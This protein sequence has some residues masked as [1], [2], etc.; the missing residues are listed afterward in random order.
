MLLT[1]AAAPVGSIHQEDHETGECARPEGQRVGRCPEA[2]SITSR[3]SNWAVLLRHRIH[4][5]G[6]VTGAAGRQ[7]HFIAKE[8]PA[9]ARSAP[10]GM[11][12]PSCG[13]QKV[14]QVPARLARQAERRFLQ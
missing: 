6:Q 7:P 9:L 12:C 10:W 2:A 11:P 3:T 1:R 13:P 8:A 5:S 4:R 14:D